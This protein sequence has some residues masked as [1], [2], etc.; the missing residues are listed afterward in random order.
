MASLNICGWLIALI[1]YKVCKNRVKS[2]VKDHDQLKAYLKGG[3]QNL[4]FLTFPNF[5]VHNLLL[6][7]NVLF[8]MKKQDCSV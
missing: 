1:H 5:V 7:N 3:L 6:T 2:P 8:Y 4:Y